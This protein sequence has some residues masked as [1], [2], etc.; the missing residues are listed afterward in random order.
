MSDMNA[1]DNRIYQEAAIASEK[2]DI[3][4]EIVR[5]N[6]HIDLFNQYMNSTENEGKKLTFILQEMGRE[7]NT[8]GS[9]TDFIEIKH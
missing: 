3:T 9:K 7:V 2:K 1:D 5:L 6:S 8:I 4:E